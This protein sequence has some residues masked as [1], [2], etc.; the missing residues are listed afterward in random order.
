MNTHDTTSPG[1]CRSF[2]D[3]AILDRNGEA[4]N[5]RGAER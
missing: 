1:Q 5:E 3:G 4:C 2:I